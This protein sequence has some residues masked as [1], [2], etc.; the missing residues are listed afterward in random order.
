MVTNDQA[1]CRNIYSALV[2]ISFNTYLTFKKCFST[3]KQHIYIYLT[4]VVRL[5][6]AV[7]NQNLNKENSRKP[8]CGRR[9]AVRWR[10][11]IK[12]WWLVYGDGEGQLLYVAGKLVSVNGKT[13]EPIQWAILEENL[14][15]AAKDFGLAWRFTFQQGNPE[16]T[17][18]IEAHPS[19]QDFP[20]KV[21]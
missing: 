10:T 13:G 11:N 21:I 5:Y 2:K 12:T 3:L 7:S 18:E 15:E 16:L 1:A 8:E 6:K 17:V 9:H 20:D 19:C 14:L 4:G